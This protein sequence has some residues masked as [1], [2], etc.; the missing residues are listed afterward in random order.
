MV[1]FRIN[2]ELFKGNGRDYSKKLLKY[3]YS[4]FLSCIFKPFENLYKYILYYISYS[5]VVAV[6]CNMVVHICN[7][8]HTES[9]RG[10]PAEETA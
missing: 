1:V 5:F 3:C 2:M 4:F 6:F 10:S 7:L 8:R 9:E